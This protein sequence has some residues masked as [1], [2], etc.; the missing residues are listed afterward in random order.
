MIRIDFTKGGV[1]TIRGIKWMVILNK[2]I[3]GLFRPRVEAIAGV[4]DFDMLE[5]TQLSISSKINTVKEF[6]K[7]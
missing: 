7:S 5:E 3:N 6:A 2:R 4:F 1:N